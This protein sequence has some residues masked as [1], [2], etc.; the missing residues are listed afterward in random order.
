MEETKEV[1]LDSDKSETDE[2]YQRE[3][4]ELLKRIYSQ[5][6]WDDDDPVDTDIDTD[7]N[8]MKNTEW[9]TSA[10][11]ARKLIEN[12]DDMV[13]I[14]EEM[15][16]D[17]LNITGKYCDYDILEKEKETIT[18]NDNVWVKTKK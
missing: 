8:V 11:V 14:E 9:S 18:K 1:N 3:N 2:R 12:P 16:S 17:V 15:Y 4:T 5:K 10:S 7:M 6:I 13:N